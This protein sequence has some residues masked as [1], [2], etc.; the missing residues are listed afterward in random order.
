MKSLLYDNPRALALALLLIFVSGMAGLFTIPQEEDPK[1]INRFAT[2]LTPFPGASAERVERLVT[3]RI[4]DALRELPEI[5]IVRSTSRTGLSSVAIELEDAVIDNDTVFSKARDQIADVVPN[6]P[7]E[8]LD[9]QFI[10]DRGYAF[11]VLT[12]IIWDSQGR[13]DPLIL[14]RVAEELQSQLRDVSGTEFVDIS[15]VVDEEVAVTLRGDLAQSLG[16]SEAQMAGIIARAD[17]KGSA[18]QLF[19]ARSEVPIEVRGELDSLDRIREIPLRA[20]PTGG[21][22]RVGDV[23]EVRR[24]LTQPEIESAFVDGQRAVIVGTRMETGLRVSDWAATVRDEIALFKADLSSGLRAEIIFDQSEYADERFGSLAINLLI[25]IGLVASILFFTL[26]FRQALLVTLAIPL[27]ALTTLAIM[28]GVGVKLHQMSVT[29]M[30]VALGLLVDAAIVMCDAI[31]R[32]LREGLTAR[33]AV[34][35]SVSKLWLPLL[36]ST[37]TTVLAFLPITLLIGGAGEFVGPIADSVIIALC[38][39]LVIALTIMPALAGRFLRDRPR[40]DGDVGRG[41]LTV[42]VLNPAFQGL[43]GLSLKAPRI[44]MLC[45]LVLPV[46]AFIGVTT[47]PSQFFPA[48]DRNQFHIQMRLGPEATLAATQEAVDVAEA[49]LRSDARIVETAWF[50]GNSAPAFYYNL[51][52]DQDGARRFAEVMVTAAELDGLGDLQNDMQATLQTALPGIQILTRTIV[53]GPPTE[54]PIELRI[55]GRDLSVLQELGQQARLIM[56][57]IPIVIGTTASVAGGQPKFW[58]DADEEEAS[59]AGLTLGSLSEALQAKFQGAQGGSVIEGDAEIPVIVR[60]TDDARASVEELGSIAVTNPNASSAQVSATPLSSLGDL[61]LEPS[62]ATITRYQGERVNTILGYV[63]AGALPSTAVNA[64]KAAAADGRW[65]MPYGYSYEFGGDDQ[66]RADAISNLLSSVGVIVT[67]TVAV[68]VLTFGSFRLGA[69]VLAVTIMS[70]GLGMLVLTI[71]G[72]PFGFQ[73]VI[74]LIGLAGVA[75]NAA[76]IIMSNLKSIPDAVSGSAEAVK[77]GTLE[78]SRHII[79]TTLTTFAGFLPL[80]LS[81]GDFWPAFASAIAGGVVLSTLVSFFFVPQAFLVL[82]RSR[83]VMGAASPQE[84]SASLDERR[85]ATA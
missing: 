53:Q 26:G 73:P 11:T 56:S 85:F 21:Q 8:A 67:L 47:L 20:S 46:L 30:I 44:S 84:A 83:P 29:G 66:A 2:V 37:A 70:M 52:M 57:E 40:D 6:L 38:S 61:V 45:A 42:P 31:G 68:L 34:R 63:E 24:Q 33:D 32:R 55:T 48:A 60:L 75:I 3:Q 4:E 13:A 41:G 35:S 10:D 69:V 80:I 62:P 82:T 17:S 28:N 64:F 15:G 58:V 76:I 12:A 25:G 9:P 22:V 14:K 81:E 49:V 72:F 78:S 27:T 16:L 1:I 7:S 74:A 77:A 36:S 43:L 59:R 19:S 71:F 5:K 50:V 65:E 39:S 79:S 54:A 51:K 18:G 23:A